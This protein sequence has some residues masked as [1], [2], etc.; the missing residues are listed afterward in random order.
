MRLAIY[1]RTLKSARGAERVI[2]SI[3]R[4]LAARGH[5]VELLLEEDDGW[6][7]EDLRQ[8]ESGVAVRCLKEAWPRKA[9]SL[10]AA[11]YVHLANLLSAAVAPRG[12]WS[13]SAKPLLRM[14]LRDRPPLYSLSRFVRRE[15][16]DAVVS[17]L[18]YP[19]MVLLMAA[20]VC[21][22]RTRFVVNVRNHISSSARNGK[23]KW[24]RSVP[25]LM[26]RFFP[27]ADGV[28]APS[29]GVAQDVAEITGLPLSDIKVIHN[30]VYREE[31]LEL[32]AEPVEHRW[33][34]GGAAPVV[35]AAGKFKPQKDFPTLLRAFARLRSQRP[36]RLI[37]LGE[38]A[39][40]AQLLA[41][42]EDLGI[43]DDLDLPG[44][45]R[46]PYA[47]FSKASVFVLSSAFEGLPNALIEALAC[48]CAVV[49]TDCPSGPSEI[50]DGGAYGR[51][52]PVGDPEA[53]AAALD[54]ALDDPP[55]RDRLIE[56]ARTFSLENS[57][58]GYERAL[59]EVVRSG[60]PLRSGLGLSEGPGRL[61]SP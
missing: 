55:A 44:H 6:L 48:G 30:P 43:A 58:A 42:A 60:Q 33:L 52:V 20:R 50:L 34:Q 11:A 36:A 5:E 27:E 3:A 24:M 47:Y 25:S 49:S 26:R 19:N 59:A 31:L 39:G 15:K 8:A 2:A 32:A 56:R 16:P 18:N 9:L 28:L 54:A 41:L 37:I 12:G 35:V 10:L 38:G 13:A 46:N 29:L 1:V 53:L 40:K 45:V 4:G 51:L 14:T 57:V 61:P 7:V 23:S 22:G 17:F 21:R